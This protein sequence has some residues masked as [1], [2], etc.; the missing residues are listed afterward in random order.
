MVADAQGLIMDSKE[1]LAPIITPYEALL[2][3]GPPQPWSGKYEM[4]FLA[5]PV[6]SFRP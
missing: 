1:F 3:F 5:L 4:D 2:A 6:R